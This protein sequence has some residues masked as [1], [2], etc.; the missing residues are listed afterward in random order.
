MVSK[1]APSSERGRGE[2][3]RRGRP[4]RARRASPPKQLTLRR[5][6]SSAAAALSMRVGA[7]AGG[8]AA[9][10]WLLMM[11]RMR[12]RGGGARVGR[13]V[14]R[15]V[16]DTARALA[17]RP[18]P[19][20]THLFFANLRA[21]RKPTSLTATSNTHPTATQSSTASSVVAR[22]AAASSG[23]G[24]GGGAPAAA[25]AA[26]SPK[27]RAR[28]G[29]ASIDCGEDRSED[30]RELPAIGVRENELPPTH[31]SELLMMLFEGWRFW[32][33]G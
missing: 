11:M 20:K 14:G 9:L 17:A 23:V 21:W 8:A 32:G 25:A 16:G 2:R 27:V 30:A 5:S 7:C 31:L 24:G 26:E 19:P 10:Y 1:T 13:P 4:S 3:R 12:R 33:R 29:W 18:P 15:G 22:A 6:I 28:D